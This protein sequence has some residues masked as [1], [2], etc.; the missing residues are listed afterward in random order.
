MSP[1]LAPCPMREVTG[2]KKKKKKMMM[3]LVMMVM[4]IIITII[5]NATINFAISISIGNSS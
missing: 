3:I 5:I 2:K 1:G 4:M